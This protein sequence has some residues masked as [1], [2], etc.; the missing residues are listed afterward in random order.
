METKAQPRLIKAFRDREHAS[1]FYDK[2]CGKCKKVARCANAAKVEIVIAAAFSTWHQIA[3]HHAPPKM[4]YILDPDEVGYC[5]LYRAEGARVR[6]QERGKQVSS[7]E[8]PD[9]GDT[10]ADEPLFKNHT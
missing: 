1:V 10:W 6:R 3:K 4:F 5:R 9:T 7:H 2:N 8:S